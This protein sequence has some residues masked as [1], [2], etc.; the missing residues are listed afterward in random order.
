MTTALASGPAPHAATEGPTVMIA[1]SR[2]SQLLG[3]RQVATA[4]GEG[5][6]TAVP[7]ARVL[8]VPT[9]EEGAGFIDEV[10]QLCDGAIEPVAVD[11][12][13]GQ[14]AIGRIGL[15]GPAG[16]RKAIIDLGEIYERHQMPPDCCDTTR[17][18]SRAAGQLI[19]AALDRGV[20]RI[21][22][23]CGGNGANDG[24]IGM[25]TELG[26]R[27]LDARRS[28]I[29]EAGGLQRLDSIDTSRRDRRLDATCI[30][31]VVDPGRSLLGKDGVVAGG[32]A[33]SARAKGL[34]RGLERYAEVVRRVLG[35]DATVL[36][37]GGA[38][39]GL[40]AGLVV[41]A[42]GRLTSRADFLRHCPGLVS[43]LATAHLVIT[44]NDPGFASVPFD[45]SSLSDQGSPA[46]ARIRP[47]RAGQAT[48]EALA[49]VVRRARALGLP[50]V[51]LG[52]RPG[53]DIDQAFAGMGPSTA[54]AGPRQ[55]ELDA[56]L[57]GR[58]VDW[59]RR[60]GESAILGVAAR[61]IAA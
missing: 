49:W 41:F 16:E 44:A 9:I 50:V 56:A 13:Y 33:A 26:I 55:V 30:E 19:V 39:G 17:A 40:G 3:P 23:S 52:C 45:R 36:D 14:A 60:S 10:V 27:F 24:G 5:I 2:V 58:V 11:G 37:G 8:R 47:A 54:L 6:R 12:P 1:A 46:W 32:T 18:S 29:V 59:L 28:E 48:R 57:A 21:I 7:G 42:G 61:R 31:A 51:S 20:H 15:I 4:I 35:V 43:T 25:A 53:W 38:C 34:E 22:I